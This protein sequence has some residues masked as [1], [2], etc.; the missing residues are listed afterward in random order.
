MVG[1]LMSRVEVEGQ[2]VMLPAVQNRLDFQVVLGPADQK[3]GRLKSTRRNLD[4]FHHCSNLTPFISLALHTFGMGTTAPS[5]SAP[6][7]TAAT[8]VVPVTETG[9]SGPT[10]GVVAPPLPS[11]TS[12][13][14]VH[15]DNDPRYVLVL[16]ASE[17]GNAQDMAERVARAF[18]AAHRRAITL[19]MDEYDVADL[20]H[21]PL[22]VFIT[23]T[24]GRGDPPP[25]MRTLWH[26][27][28]RKGLP[29]D[30]LE[31]GL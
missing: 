21:E 22:I 11:P 10:A 5:D 18:R 15:S 8:A 25:A 28:I 13:G 4:F 14:S 20:P 23:S 30:I 29:H 16:Y 31:G 7:M 1:E 24:H 2:C 12:V 26:R 19:S 27:L 9:A 6:A 17:T 3:S